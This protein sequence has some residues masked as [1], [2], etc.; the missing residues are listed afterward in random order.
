MTDKNSIYQYSGLNTEQ[1]RK[2]HEHIKFFINTVAGDFTVRNNRPGNIASL[3]EITNPPGPRT[4][5]KANAFITRTDCDSLRSANNLIKQISN[6]GHL[7]KDTRFELESSTILEVI[8]MRSTKD[9]NKYVPDMMLDWFGTVLNFYTSME[10]VT[11]EG[12]KDITSENLLP[13]PTTMNISNQEENNRVNVYNTL[14]V[15]HFPDNPF[16]DENGLHD[17]ICKLHLNGAEMTDESKAAVQERINQ[18]WWHKQADSGIENLHAIH[19]GPKKVITLRHV[20]K[21]VSGNLPKRVLVPI[22]DSG[23]HW[24]L[25]VIDLPGQTTNGSVSVIDPL[26]EKK[27]DINHSSSYYS[28]MWWAKYVALNLDKPQMPHDTTIESDI[29][30]P[31]SDM[32]AKG[33]MSENLSRDKNESLNHTGRRFLNVQKD[34]VSCG[35]YVMFMM[36]MSV[37][38]YGKNTDLSD[39]I[40]LMHGVI[41]RRTKTVNGLRRFKLW[42]TDLVRNIHTT[43]NECDNRNLNANTLPPPATATNDVA[44]ILANMDMHINPNDDAHGPG[45]D[46]ESDELNF[47][48]IFDDQLLTEELLHSHDSGWK[49]PTSLHN[50]NVL[51]GNV[52][53]PQ[54]GMSDLFD[55]RS[56]SVSSPI[57]PTQPSGV[58]KKGLR[59]K[60]A[61]KRHPKT[62]SNTESEQ[63]SEAGEEDDDVGF[64]I[65]NRSIADR[66]RGMSTTSVIRI[67]LTDDDSTVLT[68]KKTT[69][70]LQ[71]VILERHD[72]FEIGCTR[73]RRGVVGGKLHKEC[74]RII[75]RNLYQQSAKCPRNARDLRLKKMN[76]ILSTMQ[77]CHIYFI[78]IPDRTSMLK[79]RIAACMVIEENI[80]IY[81]EFHA[82]STYMALIH[83][84]FSEP[85]LEARVYQG[86]LLH[87]VL[88]HHFTSKSVY[89]VMDQKKFDYRNIAGGVV[90]LYESFGFTKQNQNS[91]FCRDLI[92]DETAVLGKIRMGSQLEANIELDTE[93]LKEVGI[94]KLES[95]S[96]TSVRLHGNGQS[97]HMGRYQVLKSN[98]GWLNVEN[99]FVQSLVTD[100]E[101]NQLK[102]KGDTIRITSTGSSTQCKPRK[103]MKRDRTDH[104][105]GGLS[106]VSQHTIQTTID[107]KG[108]KITVDT[109]KLDKM[110]AKYYVGHSRN[111]RHNADKNEQKNNAGRATMSQLLKFTYNADLKRN[112]EHF[113]Q[114]K[115]SMS[116]V[117]FT[118]S[119]LVTSRFPEIAEVMRKTYD[120][121]D[122]LKSPMFLW[123]TKKNRKLAEYSL[124]HWLKLISKCRI[125]VQKFTIDNKCHGQAVIDA[126]KGDKSKWHFVCS[127]NSTGGSTTHCVGIDTHT[128]KIYDCEEDWE[129]ELNVENL[130]R[131]CG[132]G[133]MFIKF[134]YVVAVVYSKDVVDHVYNSMQLSGSCEMS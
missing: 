72:C 129:L 123:V 125:R 16:L 6:D 19:S 97:S 121:N 112:N 32:N 81:H 61:L 21:S 116:C 114:Q 49:T 95:G 41:S 58:K 7:M 86:L 43:I 20:L 84:I 131:C 57:E 54:K 34:D 42:L 90:P 134:L 30:I 23:H 80:E 105:S 102:R 120:E 109:M 77:K 24:V 40:P 36:L 53:T 25:G 46:I 74:A 5:Q 111:E 104:R 78:T 79:A 124:N 9:Q 52:I 118:A 110:R 126:L 55:G 29:Q 60:I 65:N 75:E 122:E 108:R 101:L 127:L 17:A 130:T 91:R 27:N 106:N 18:W 115:G 8:A 98:W 13:V 103:A 14:S 26:I 15:H 66:G 73:V 39:L 67:T 33:Y 94:Y 71:P 11:D 128:N 69:L 107:P 117:W 113:T 99:D 1:L 28:S 4:K 37:H 92:D 38:D 51:P 89:L 2:I 83:Y 70:Y 132:Q 22:N 31:I 35:I 88:R 96:M 100:T 3:T 62:A 87:S 59:L 119:L 68:L 85:E 48:S 50:T 64:P 76:E 82:K 45:N 10:Q 133:K 44:N 47:E 93:S 63:V 56:D 12:I